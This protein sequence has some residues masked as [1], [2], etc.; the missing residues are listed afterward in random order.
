MQGLPID[1]WVKI[2]RL[3]DAIEFY[4]NASLVCKEWHTVL[5][6]HPVMNLFRWHLIRP[7]QYPETCTLRYMVIGRSALVDH[8]PDSCKSLKW[9]QETIYDCQPNRVLMDQRLAT[10]LQ[11]LIVFLLRNLSELTA[12]FQNLTK[13]MLLN[14]RNGPYDRKNYKLD[15]DG[16]KHFPNLKKLSF[17]EF[18]R[19]NFISFPSAMMDL[20]IIA[21]DTFNRDFWN[22]LPQTLVRCSVRCQGASFDLSKGELTRLTNLFYLGLECESFA[23]NQLPPLPPNIIELS[24]ICAKL[25]SLQNLPASL[26]TCSFVLTKWT[27]SN[28]VIDN[29]PRDLRTF[30][31][32]IKHGHM[33]ILPSCIVVPPRVSQCFIH[34]PSKNL[35]LVFEDSSTLVKLSRPYCLEELD[36]SPKLYPNLIYLMVYVYYSS[37]IASSISILL[38]NVQH[39]AVVETD[40]PAKIS[41]DYK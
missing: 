41:R 37:A 19:I 16:V 33:S 13:L 28:A 39:I 21:A 2:F 8:V 32:V 4:R 36:F 29:L 5:R 10:R 34:V 22:M 17:F 9:R 7:N 30:S 40:G 35:Q 25:T 38:K 3:T 11:S 27:S 26:Q 15:F 1:L 23:E 14:D 12:C 6:R 24:I 31:F 20:T 18:P